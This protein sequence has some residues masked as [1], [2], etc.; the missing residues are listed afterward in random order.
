[1]SLPV[2]ALLVP[3]MLAAAPPAAERPPTTPRLL[4]K[5]AAEPGPGKV[6]ATFE[7]LAAVPLAIETVPAFALRPSDPEDSGRPAFRAP[8][9][10]DTSKPLA[11]NRRATLKLARREKQT[12][13]VPLESLYWD[14]YQS[15]FWPF[16]PL[17][18]VALP[19]RYDLVLE[20]LDPES[21]Y[22]WRS[23]QI[24]AVVKKTGILQ[25]VKPD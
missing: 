8:I 11:A 1:M 22:V 4:V 10:L 3:A 16:R 12:I 17:R 21:G 19:G 13:V 6:R 23:N 2:A 7:N 15:V 24:P 5:V 25:L 18:S 14:H 9:D 20:V